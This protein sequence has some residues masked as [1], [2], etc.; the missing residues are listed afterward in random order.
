MA[1]I[2]IKESDLIKLIETAMDLDIYSQPTA[3]DTDNGNLDT[4]DTIEDIVSKLKE[5]LYMIKQ[6]KAV[7]WEVEN[8]I[9]KESDKVNQIYDR[10]K[11][12]K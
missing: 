1:K 6:G 12:D 10:L 3:V 7:D 11:Y 8:E 5:L 9:N 2:L 4:E